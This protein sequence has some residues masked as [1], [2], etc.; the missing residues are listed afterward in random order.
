MVWPSARKQEKDLPIEKDL[1]QFEE[2]M[3]HF[4]TGWPM[5]N[6]NDSETP[7]QVGSGLVPVPW[8]ERNIWIQ[9]RT[10]INCG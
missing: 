2:L 1:G 10:T 5:A 4:D 9:K 6:L 7:L 8:E 3:A